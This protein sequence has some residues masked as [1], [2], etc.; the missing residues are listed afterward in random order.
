VPES[1]LDALGVF[2]SLVPT[3]SADPA[4]EANTAAW[5]ALLG[6]DRPFLCAFSDGDPI[7]RGADAMFLDRVPGTAGQ[8]HTTIEG[9]GHFL[10]EDKGVQLAAVI[11]DFIAAS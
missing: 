11:A 10:Q 3:S 8:P 5:E 9:A 2:P 4:H 7:T 1:F 6:Y